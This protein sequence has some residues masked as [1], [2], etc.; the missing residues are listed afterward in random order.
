MYAFVVLIG[1]T[2]FVVLLSWFGTRI[3]PSSEMRCSWCSGKSRVFILLDE[4]CLALGYGT[5][6]SCA[7]Y[8][9]CGFRWAWLHLSLVSSSSRVEMCLL[10]RSGK[11]LWDG[12]INVIP[13][14]QWHSSP[15]WQLGSL[16]TGVHSRISS[17]V[18]N[19]MRL[20]MRR[21]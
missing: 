18:V 16:G 12:N 1:S 6:I 2:T 15:C 3:F 9:C 17:G 4:G 11:Y 14:R 7:S 10:G 8:F 13:W 21:R 5:L 20:E 19:F